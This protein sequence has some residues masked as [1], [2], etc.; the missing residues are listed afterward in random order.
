VLL[1]VAGYQ[2]S[3]LNAVVGEYITVPEVESR[4]EES[5]AVRTG[6]LSSSGTAG[7]SP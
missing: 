4:P 2:T 7:S 1:T 6:T 3:V 5:P